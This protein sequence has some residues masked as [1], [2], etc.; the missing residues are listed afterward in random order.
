MCVV[1]PAARD[2]ICGRMSYNQPARYESFLKLRPSSDLDFC[3]V[4][5]IRSKAVSP[6]D[7]TEC[8]ESPFSNDFIHK[9]RPIGGWQQKS[10]TQPDLASC[11]PSPHLW[12][13]C[14]RVDWRWDMVNKLAVMVF[15]VALVGGLVV[16]NWYCW[17]ERV[18]GGRWRLSQSPNRPDWAER[19]LALLARGRGRLENW[20]LKF[21]GHGLSF[22]TV[23]LA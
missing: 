4:K 14:G 9:S 23:P 22:C 8:T 13:A 11:K 19:M 5:A 17:G 18:F 12:V 2:Y 15:V 6:S 7:A 21:G 3:L 16:L 1:N 10:N 20:S